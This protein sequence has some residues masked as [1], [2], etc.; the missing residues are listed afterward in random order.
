MPSGAT[1]VFSF[2][3]ILLLTAAVNG[4]GATLM[5]ADALSATTSTRPLRQKNDAADVDADH[6]AQGGARQGAVQ[7]TSYHIGA[8]TVPLYG[9]F[10]PLKAI[11]EAL[12][13]AGHTV[14]LFTESAAWCQSF[15]RHH[16]NDEDD[17]HPP[18]Q[19]PTPQDPVVTGSVPIGRLYCQLLPRSDIW[20]SEYMKAI[21][22][23]PDFSVTLVKML[24]AMSDYMKGHLRHYVEL[25]EWQLESSSSPA[26]HRRPF[27]VILADYATWPAAAIADLL[28]IP[29]VSVNPMTLNMPLSPSD[30]MPSMGANEAFPLGF[31]NRLLNL[32]VRSSPLV[33]LFG[34]Y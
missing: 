3:S 17:S 4:P 12:L 23:E 19:R 32:I 13:E 6:G 26:H 31:G 15:G 16:R 10:L 20:N 2:L 34:G 33:P 22:E 14:T 30:W 28:H 24:G 29:L 21:S 1:R 9:H 27:D 7:T 18:P 5:A 8:M 25:V 11:V